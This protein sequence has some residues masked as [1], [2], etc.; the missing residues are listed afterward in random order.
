MMRKLWCVGLIFLASALRA[1]VLID[2]NGNGG[3]ENGTTLSAN[4]WTAVNSPF[5]FWCAGTANGT[6]TG[7][8]G[9]RCMY[10]S[11]T[12]A[13]TNNNYATFSTVIHVYSA[14]FT[15]TASEPNLALSFRLKVQGNSG[16]HIRVYLAPSTYTPTAGSAP[17]APAEILT[18][19]T[20]LYNYPSW[21]TFTFNKCNVAPGT[22]RLIFTWTN[23]TT[24]NNPA[25]AI[26]DVSLVSSGCGSQVGTGFVSIST[27]PYTII[28]TTSC[29]QLN[30]LTSANTVVNGSASYLASE[31]VVYHFKAPSAGIV[32]AQL[33]NCS[34]PHSA[35]MVYR[36]CPVSSLTCGVSIPLAY[37]QNQAADKNVSFNVV[38]DSNYYILI[39]GLYGCATY[40]LTITAP[41]S[42]IPNDNACG[43]IPLQMGRPFADDNSLA[44]GAGEGAGGL[45]WITGSLN[46]VWYSFTAPSS[47]QVHVG[48]MSG[49]L[50]Q[51]QIE[52]YTGSCNA[53]TAVA[54]SC[55]SSATVGCPGPT[56]VGLVPG[57]TYYLRLDGYDMNFGSYG[58]VVDIAPGNVTGLKTEGRAGIEMCVPV[59]SSVMGTIGCGSIA[60]IPPPGSVSNPN[61]NPN[62]PNAGCLL[63]GEIH[64]TFFRLNISTGGTL[65]WTFSANAAGFY[66]W[67]LWNI[68]NA[69]VSD[70]TNNLLPPVRCNWNA[71]AGGLTGMQSVI[72]PGG[73]P[74]NFEAPL[75]VAAGE[76]YLLC[77][78]NWNGFGAPYTI[79]F[80]SSTC[81][82]GGNV[83]TWI[84]YMN[85][86][87]VQLGNWSTCVGPPSCSV[88][89]IINPS[90]NQPV[91]ATNTTV[92]NLTIAPGASLTLNAGV[93]LTI[94]GNFNNYGSLIASPTST[95]LFNGSGT[96]YL[97]GNFTNTNALGNVTITKTT[98]TVIT[99]VPLD[100]AGNFTT[101]NAT[102]IFNANGQYI[103]LSGNFTNAAGG[104][105]FTN[106]GTG[107]L[108]FRGSST[109]TY[110]PGGTLNLYNVWINQTGS[111]SV[112]LA[113]NLN[114]TGTLTLTNGRI[115]TNTHEVNVTNPA[116]TSVNGGSASSYVDGNLRRSVNSTGS[117]NFPVGQSSSGKG[118]QR[119]NVNFTSPTN[120][121]NLLVRFSSY[122]IVPPALGV[123]DCGFNYNMPA[124]DNGY[125]SITSTPAMTSGQYTITLYNTAGTY[126]NATGALNWTVMRN[127][128]GGWGLMGNCAASTVN[129]VVRTGLTAFSDFGTAQAS[130][131]LPVE[132]V[133]FEGSVVAEGNLLSWHTAS[134]HQNS[135]FV[136]EHSLEGTHFR[137]LAIIWGAGT[138]TEPQQY[139]HLHLRPEPRLNY[140]RLQ[141]VDEDGS[142]A[143]SSVIVLD[144]SH[145]QYPN[146]TVQ[147]NPTEG[148]MHLLIRTPVT[149]EVSVDITDVLGK[150]VYRFS[151]E[152][153]QG[154]Y[155]V[156][157][158]LE[159]Q[160]GIYLVAV[161][162]HQSGMHEL[163]RIVKK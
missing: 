4:G 163:H 147:P 49:T 149:Q 109:Q 156:D 91:L 28:N 27:L 136:L 133:S 6:I 98:G 117:Y 121:T 45:C 82:F 26:D 120:V 29:G 129:Q 64:P 60:E 20:G 94:C 115:A 132:L 139:S 159:G 11:S 87:F 146:V 12:N 78:T 63:N 84:G 100:I 32:T 142:V 83:A 38:A 85:T 141:Q 140:Y 16:S 112:N 127:A 152:L 51:A 128:G 155:Q 118:F 8:T 81:T 96:Q 10:V 74:A 97:N 104:T 30:D 88:D 130:L 65:A 105:T 70:I 61:V 33:R 59:F 57:T 46:T 24:S 106:V 14:N 158:L 39:D 73:N 113:G 79:D 23:N 40:D 62:P 148:T 86:D 107:T 108:E 71:T 75:T 110:T 9:A 126:T 21:T 144:N 3:L 53:P 125:W 25:A 90:G 123:N 150:S 72:P 138:T 93:T 162:F 102:S 48:F 36:N 101:T 80:S 119:V 69:T 42:A 31:E 77:V 114:V 154:E 134:E 22:Y 43:A 52:L 18:P 56:Y 135:H 54:G 67:I 34:N 99:N 111:G 66:D 41:A 5:N 76:S 50:L 160:P 15:V 13:C 55:V 116:T 37:N 44:T 35:I 153:Q 58:I 92:R 103:R 145:Q 151:Q 161:T 68:T 95:V 124:L 143:Y 1:A 47:G 19:P 122:A 157:A 137:P 17:V 2:P 89:A 131:N 7:Y